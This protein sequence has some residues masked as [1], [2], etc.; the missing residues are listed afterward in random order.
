MPSNGAGDA[1]E[2]HMNQNAV[3]A[4]SGM[5]S[6]IALASTLALEGILF[7]TCLIGFASMASGA[8]I[9]IPAIT[10][11]PHNITSDVTTI[12]GHITAGTLEGAFG[13]F[14]AA[15]VFASAGK[16]RSLSLVYR[17]NVPV[18]DVTAKL[19][20]KKFDAGKSPFTEPVQM[21]FL[22]SNGAQRGMRRLVEP[23]ILEPNIDL[24]DAFYYVELDVGGLT[25]GM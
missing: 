5:R 6:L 18:G 11:V 9:N 10:F 13:R 1:G 23:D 3:G 15:V 12:E 17:D 14:F 22:R 19:F 20:K 4:R 2:I 8:V 16:V 25:S 24:V 7:A 21:A